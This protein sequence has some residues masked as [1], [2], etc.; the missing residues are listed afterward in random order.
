VFLGDDCPVT[1]VNEGFFF[2]EFLY[3]PSDCNVRIEVLPG[4]QVLLVPENVSELIW[5]E[6]VGLF[7]P[8]RNSVLKNK[9]KPKSLGSLCPLRFQSRSNSQKLWLQQLSMLK[10]IV[11][12]RDLVY[13]TFFKCLS[14]LTL[15]RVT[16]GAL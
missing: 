16:L 15:H 3:H 11:L 8:L 7:C 9:T 13:L 5:S 10:A 14:D 2:F 12:P 6:L 1:S 4:D